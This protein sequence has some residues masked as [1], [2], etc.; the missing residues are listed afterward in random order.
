MTRRDFFSIE[1]K[2]KNIKI[3]HLSKRMEYGNIV[4]LW[5]IISSTSP[6][7]LLCN[8]ILKEKQIFN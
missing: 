5:S 3:S 7:T 8:Y 6:N 2:V 4:Y 1:N